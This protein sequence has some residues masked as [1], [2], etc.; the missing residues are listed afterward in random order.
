MKYKTGF[1]LIELLV[2]IAI[3]GILVGLL[4]PAIQG[5]REASRRTVCANNIRQ[6]GL[7]LMGYESS[8]KRLPSGWQSHNQTGSLTLPGWGWSALVLPYLENQNIHNKINFGQSIDHPTN[9]EI[10]RTPLHLFLC[11]SEPET[12]VVSLGAHNHGEFMASR[13]NYSGV[14][15]STEVED[16]PSNGN[17]TFYANSKIRLSEIK[18]GL[19][20]TMI[21]GERR[22]DLG[23]VSWV[24]AVDKINEPYL[25]I[26]GVADHSPNGPRGNFEDFR[27]YHPS[28]INATMADGSVQF[29][30][31]S[32]DEEIFQGLATR[33]GKEVISLFD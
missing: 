15:G 27:S 17:G 5:A 9:A 19:S 4:L 2:V 3:I 1:S 14:F 10:I 22:N 20:H 25:R 31:H 21:V 12:N 24:G 13:S 23:A 33:S 7:G 18:D 26:V 6:V 16:N 28:G 29:I 32:I 11:P 8:L 30:S